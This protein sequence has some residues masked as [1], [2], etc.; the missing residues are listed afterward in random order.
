MPVYVSRGT[1]PAEAQDAVALR[2]IFEAI[3]AESCPRAYNFHLH[4]HHSDGK[5]QAEQ[6]MEQALDI[7]LQGIAIT[8]HHTIAGYR[9]AQQWLEDWRWKHPVSS[10]ADGKKV[11][12]LWTGVE[13][14]SN[15]LGI[16]VH[17]LCYAFNPDHSAMQPYLQGKPPSGDDYQAGNI[18][19]AAHQAGGIAVLAHPARYP[20]RS[21]SE[22][23]PAAVRLGVDGVE[24]YY[25]YDNPA[26]WRSSPKQTEVVHSIVTA[27]PG[28]FHTCGTDTHGLSLLQRL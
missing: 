14:N 24:T 19:A 4:T 27:H 23:I 1:V 25:A 7:G 9:K 12:R 10:T 15:L 28:I 5:L 2:A 8:D 22:L 20:R 18:I 26:P 13:V 17:L 21:P 16:D 3:T 11:P 6:V